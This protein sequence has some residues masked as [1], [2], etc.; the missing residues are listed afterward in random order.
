MIEIVGSPI[1]KFSHAHTPQLKSYTGFLYRFIMVCCNYDFF[2][3]KMT[4]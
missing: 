4:F 3:K 1:Y 2:E